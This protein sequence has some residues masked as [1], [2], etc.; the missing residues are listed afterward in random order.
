M[1]S[2]RILLAED[3]AHER[4]VIETNLR[5]AL[6]ANMQAVF[7]FVDHAEA[8]VERARALEFDLFILDIDFSQS[9]RS[10]GM[11][12]L[13]ASKLI[14]AL[15]PSSYAVVISSSEEQEVMMAAVDQ[16]AVD[17]YIRRSSISYPELA[18]L[19]KQALLNRLHAD[20]EV[21]DKRYQFLTE[22]PAAKRI[23]RRVDSVLP[24]QNV[25]IYGETGTGK[26]L[27]ARRI[28]ANTKLFD[29]KR[30]LKIL[31]CSALSPTLFEGEVFGHRKG[32]FTGAV[33]DRIGAL[34]LANGGDLFLDEIHNIPPALQQ[35]LLRVLNDGVFSPVGSNEEIKSNFRIIA[36]T[37]V[38]IEEAISSGKLLP[39]FVERLRKIQLNLIPLRD[40][41]EDISFLVERH[42]D[43][44]GSFDK[45]FSEDALAYM[46]QRK[47]TGNIR[48]LNG[49]V[50]TAIAEVKI[51]VVSRAHLER[52]FGNESGAAVAKTVLEAQPTQLDTAVA[53]LLETNL[54]L[55]AIIEQIERTYLNRVQ[56]R[57]QSI[58]E[59]ADAIGYSRATLARRLS[60]L[61]ISLKQ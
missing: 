59:M 2:L 17:W 55:S 48:E 35:K 40:R 58:R 16:F 10:R 19:A 49:F 38:P 4:L 7:T 25:L 30:P 5:K 20:G 12:G 57:Y 42:L 32:A 34:Q 36:A 52:I 23:L 28:H 61:G 54:P 27:I 8:A 18:W 1:H 11:T 21:L 51:P 43:S 26:E 44:V 29:S 3:M 24:T 15:R 14:K 6:P 37:N 46:R 13:Q 33:S 31:D 47:W 56:G 60:E 22:S 45:E 53:S 9:E 41:P 50:D 39:D